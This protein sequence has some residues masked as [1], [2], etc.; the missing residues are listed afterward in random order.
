MT[1]ATQEWVPFVQTFE[2]G[3]KFPDVNEKTQF[4]LKAKPNSR[5]ECTKHT[6][7]QIKMVKIYQLTCTDP[8]RL[9]DWPALRTSVP[10]EPNQSHPRCEIV[11]GSPGDKLVRVVHCCFLV[12]FWSPKFNTSRRTPKIAANSVLL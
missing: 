2:K 11:L 4:C 9:C 10:S 8:K 5:P 6:L 7:F 12:I 1:L 3:F